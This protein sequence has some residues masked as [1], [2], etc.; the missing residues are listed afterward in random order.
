MVDVASTVVRAVAGAAVRT[1][2]GAAVQLPPAPQCE[3]EKPLVFLVHGHSPY[4]KAICQIRLL[5]SRFV[6]LLCG[7]AHCFRV[8][9]IIFIG[10]RKRK[11]NKKLK[12]NEK[13]IVK[14]QLT[15]AQSYDIVI[16]Q[17]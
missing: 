4:H 12:E 17:D 2:A 7:T 16:S 8:Y 10:G 9:Y 5:G 3:L 6:I 15:G 11:N 13:S 14:N 1:A